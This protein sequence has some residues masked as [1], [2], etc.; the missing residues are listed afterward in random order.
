MIPAF[1]KIRADTSFYL[2]NI[3]DVQFVLL[4]IFPREKLWILE[5]M[6]VHFQ[7]SEIKAN[8]TV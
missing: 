8:T 6:K 1:V 7:V 5:F 2:Q 3:I 4:L